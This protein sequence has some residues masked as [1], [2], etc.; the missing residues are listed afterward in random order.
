MA[1]SVL[2]IGGGIAG[3]EASLNLADYGFQVYL[4]DNFPTIGGQMALLDK[5]F[6]TNDCSICI[7]APKMYDVQKNP[8]IKILTNCEIRR[9]NRNN[10]IFNVRVLK[11]PRFIDEEKCKGCGKCTEVCP[12]S[13][14]D[15]IDSKIGGLRKL[16]YIPFPQ[17][18]PNY[19]LIDPDC[20]FG[21]KKD[22]GACVGGCIIDCIQCRECPIA[23]CVKACKE[24]GGDAVMLWQRE[25]L[26]D[27]EV[28]SI[29]VASGIDSFKPP[30][31]LYGY[32]V[33]DNVITNFQ[34]ER[35]MNAGGP[36][37]GKIIRPSDGAHAK[38]IA[39]IQCVGREK[40]G[41]KPEPIPYCSKACCMI[42]T[43]QTIVTLEHESN[44]KAY[45]LYNHLQTYGKGFYEFYRRAKELGV[46]YVKGKP[47]DVSEDPKTKNLT[48][49]FE[50]LDKGKVED[51]EL[52]L[53]VLSTGLI[54]RKSNK[55]L[56]K[57]L[58]IDLDEYGFFK[59]AD[60]INTPFETNVKGI[61]V[62]GGAT[63]PIDISESVSQAIGASVK[64]VLTGGA[65]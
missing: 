18:V 59:E 2:I 35:M 9:A 25:E 13:V 16:I 64:V 39:G 20:R 63:G 62:C 49:R 24:E 41:D 56:S 58:K 27:L 38:R 21:K 60:P 5:T 43:K 34:Y 4:L 36:T 14:P 23:L 31:G 6:P 19:Y 7:E 50:D 55:R 52:D 46:K 26:L 51:L 33:Y 15:D 47:S 29:I 12:V 10:G 45:I 28:N 40:R 65:K 22:D 1:N 57:I 61:Y 42:A 17:A 11:K 8:N 3:I 44:V 48:I 30:C 37:Q 32:D 54:P 53:L